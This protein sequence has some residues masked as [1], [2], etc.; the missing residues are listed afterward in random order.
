MN[1]NNTISRGNKFCIT[2]KVVNVY[3][4]TIDNNLQ[5]EKII[6][7]LFVKRL[8]HLARTSKVNLNMILLKMIHELYVCHFERQLLHMKI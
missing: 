4:D 6:E 5:S 2:V 3:H 1:E 7:N 8:K